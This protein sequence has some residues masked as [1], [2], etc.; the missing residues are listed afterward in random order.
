MEDSSIYIL[1]DFM[2]S[3]W[4]EVVERNCVQF[5]GDCDNRLSGAEEVQSENF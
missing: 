2:A 1:A 4:M 3:F 5:A